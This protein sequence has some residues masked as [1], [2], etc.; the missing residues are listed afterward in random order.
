MKR[1]AAIAALVLVLVLAPGA[2]GDGPYFEGLQTYFGCKDARLVEAAQMH[3]D[4]VAGNQLIA[5]AMMVGQCIASPMP[6]PVQV[7]GVVKDIRSPHQGEL[8]IFE[9]VVGGQ[10]FYWSTSAEIGAEIR[11]FFRGS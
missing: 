6:V 9:F 2:K 4:E 7:S 1:I 3:E 11:A 10:K 8:T 5:D